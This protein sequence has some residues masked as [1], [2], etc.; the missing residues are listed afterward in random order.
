MDRLVHMLTGVVQRHFE[1]D[2]GRSRYNLGPT[3]PAQKGDLE[4]KKRADAVDPD[5]VADMGTHVDENTFLVSSFTGH[6]SGPYVI[7]S[8]PAR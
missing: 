2:E 6:E 5:K 4:R 7:E 1:R 8:R 3:N